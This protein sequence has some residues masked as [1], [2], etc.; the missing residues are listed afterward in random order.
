MSTYY[1][2]SLIPEALIASMLEPRDFGTYLAVG[3]KKRTRGQAMFFS[4]SRPESLPIDLTE[5]HER[6]VP[7]PDGEPKHSLYLSIYR[8]LERAPMQSIGSL[9]MVTPDGRVLEIEAGEQLP[10]S[11][12]RYHL[13]Q[14]VCPVHTRVVSAL[15]PQS[16]TQYITNPEHSIFVPRICFTELRL[17]DLANNPESGSARD[18]PFHAVDHLRDCLVQLRDN[19]GKETKT[20]DRVHP[21]SFPYQT[22]AGGVYL[23]DSREL[24]VYPF[25]SEKELQSTYYEWWRSAS[26]MSDLVG[27]V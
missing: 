4:L 17:G 27:S 15:A 16:F 18:L 5:V 23:G 9:Y 20:V 11:D 26:I 6:C 14:E 13:Y 24:R 7:H 8:V 22:V 21:Q 19:P 25:P 12:Q 1:Y 2:L 10:S 3:T